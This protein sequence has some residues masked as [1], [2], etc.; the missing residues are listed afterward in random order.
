MKFPNLKEAN[1]LVLK[2]QQELEFA[3]Q[4]LELAESFAR[5]SMGELPIAKTH[6]V[7]VDCTDGKRGEKRKRDDDSATEEYDDDCDDIKQYVAQQ[8]EVTEKL[9]TEDVE[10]FRLV[11]R[12][13][14]FETTNTER[15]SPGWR[16]LA[17][18]AQTCR[19]FQR[20]ISAHSGF[21]IG[22]GE[23]RHSTDL[24][25]YAQAKVG[26]VCIR[27]DIGEGHYPLDIGI[28][29]PVW[30]TDGRLLNEDIVQGYTLHTFCTMVS[31]ENEM[32]F[33]AQQNKSIKNP[34]VP[35][36]A[37]S[38]KVGSATIYFDE[39]LTA[40]V[41]SGNTIVDSKMLPKLTQHAEIKK[42]CEELERIR[43]GD[44]SE[45]LETARS[46]IQPKAKRNRLYFDDS[47]RKQ[48]NTFGFPFLREND[49]QKFIQYENKDCK[50][51]YNRDS[52]DDGGSNQQFRILV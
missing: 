1:D 29:Y 52:S 24:P 32:N 40:D 15:S 7:K 21:L 16:K 20:R 13:K 34:T 6:I 18:L 14:L 38:F 39:L 4:Q 28:E 30:N 37:L 31:A 50:R 19:M 27:E 43:S 51:D 23:H 36:G 35:T 8:L 46:L 42:E 33:Q 47:V 22:I 10:I 49:K 45:I 41:K 25:W 44:F 48:F 26:K 12:S 9:D 3:K 17:Y 11:K 5:I 2:K